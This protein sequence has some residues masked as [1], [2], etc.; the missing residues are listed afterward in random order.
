MEGGA[1]YWKGMD[2]YTVREE[3]LISREGLICRGRG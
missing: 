1:G 2:K 3:E